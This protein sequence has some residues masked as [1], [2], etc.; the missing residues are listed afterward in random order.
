MN[1][2]I[3]ILKSPQDKNIYRFIR[4]P[5]ELDCLLIS[6]PGLNFVLNLFSLP[7]FQIVTSLLPVCL[8][9]LVTVMIL[10]K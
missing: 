1:L 3:D 2:N 10:L 5:N 8:L 4:L 7:L 6:D 9:T